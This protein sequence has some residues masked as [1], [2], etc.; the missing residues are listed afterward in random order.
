MKKHFILILKLVAFTLLFNDELKA[1][2][3]DSCTTAISVQNIMNLDDTSILI[4]HNINWY[5]FQN[6]SSFI[7]FEFYKASTSPIL[8]KFYNIQ[9]LKGSCSSN[10]IVFDTTIVHGT[11]AIIFELANQTSGIYFIKI[12]NM[13][14]INCPG[15]I[16]PYYL[17]LALKNA[18]Y[19]SIPWPVPTYISCP[20]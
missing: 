10:T 18:N 5:E 8:G 9:I 15:C 2:S 17:G 14:T 16:A 1:Q 11:N 4:S 13:D 7:F 20:T 19:S 3:G 6:D 12:Q